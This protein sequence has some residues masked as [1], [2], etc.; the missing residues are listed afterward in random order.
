MN[1]FSAGD[2]LGA[3]ALS[4]IGL[5]LA[6]IGDPDSAEF[7]NG[8]V[9]GQGLLGPKRAY[10]HTGTILGFVPEAMGAGA[11]LLPI[12]GV[13]KINHE[14]VLANKRIKILLDKFYVHDFPGNGTHRFLCEFSG[15]NQVAGETEELRF[16]LRSSANDRSSAGIN[17][18]PIFLG[19]TVGADGISF[20][21]RT[22]NVCNDTDETIL[23]T[24][25]SP[26]F[27]T[28]LSLLHSAQ[29]A[30]KPFSSLAEAVVRTAVQR[31]KNVQVHS[32]HLGLDFTDSAGSARLQLGSY[33]VV[34]SDDVKGWDWNH[35]EWNRDTQMIQFKHETA[36][37][38]P[39]NF[40]VFSVSSFKGDDTV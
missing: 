1:K 31:K 21:G 40:M 27:K 9:S 32:F 23:S 22:V 19:L 2:S 16:A 8:A 5:Y 37:E 17:G 3:R 14:P 11:S 4:N 20:E 30:L 15:K 24:L 25:E 28:G 6:E 34:Q 36:K 38:F 18:H 33:I 26:A 39:F 13:S 10:T 29:P 12:H 7:A 35:Y